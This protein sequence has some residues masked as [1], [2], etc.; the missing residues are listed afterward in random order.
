V[1]T[2]PFS[3]CLTGNTSTHTRKPWELLNRL[4]YLLPH[5]GRCG[6]HLEFAYGQYFQLISGD[7]TNSEV[8]APFQKK[9]TEV[10]HPA[11]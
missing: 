1:V 6:L 5:S 4:F 11:K 9:N 8:I 10:I 3:F 2:L 7:T